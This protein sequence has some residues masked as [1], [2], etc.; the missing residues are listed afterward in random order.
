MRVMIACLLFLAAG[1]M[2]AQAAVD[3]LERVWVGGS[4]YV[5]LAEWAETI[6]YKI[7]WPRKD[8][9][10]ELRGHNSRLEFGADSRRSWID[11]VAVWLSLPVINRSMT[12]LI[13]LVDV[14]TTLDPILFPRK[15]AR[16]I[17]TICI[18]AGHGG[19]D[20]GETANRNLEKTYTL[21]LARELAPDLKA[22]G[23][24]V[25]LTRTEDQ[26]VELSERAA[27]AHRHGADLF[28]S[29]HYNSASST[30]RGV[31]TYCMTP[32][33]ANSSQDG[34]GKGEHPAEEGNTQ[35]QRNVL[36]AW[37]V[38]KSITHSLPLED[39]GMKRAR[40]EVLRQARMPAILVE[41]GFM[42]DSS[43]A[44]HIYDPK[45]RKRMAQAIADGIVKYKETLE[46]KAKLA[47]LDHLPSPTAPKP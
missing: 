8:E 26:A 31:E 20:G 2:P 18:D 40:Y 46:P 3:G 6:G 7:D 38:Q 32:A 13:S 4:Q 17:E 9:P 11:G 27:L 29:L 21:L 15:G 33:G 41:G 12:P 24:R 44:H 10:I 34:G 5:R 19:K 36:L 16:P 35:D 22:A 37:N 1:F 39:R 30:V 25:F 47:G 45:F 28:V 43:D 42:T 23:F 14:E